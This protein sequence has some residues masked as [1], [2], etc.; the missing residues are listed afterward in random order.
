MGISEMNMN[1]QLTKM[2]LNTTLGIN[3]LINK[4]VKNLKKFFD[5]TEYSIVSGGNVL[6]EAIASNT[7][8]FAFKN[9]EHQK[10]AINYFDKHKQIIN[11][12]KINNNSFKKIDECLKNKTFQ[13]LRKKKL[14][15]GNGLEKAKKIIIKFVK[16]K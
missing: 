16:Q 6:F 1:R 15:D 11:L 5:K 12:G 4:N 2:F 13:N 10:Y 3:S 8:V 14:V 9:Y 7:K